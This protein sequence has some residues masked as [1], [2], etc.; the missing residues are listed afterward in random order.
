MEDATKYGFRAFVTTIDVENGKNWCAHCGRNPSVGELVWY[1]P[2]HT[3]MTCWAKGCYREY[4]DRQI[5]R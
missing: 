2:R 4:A 3:R 5:S 1:E